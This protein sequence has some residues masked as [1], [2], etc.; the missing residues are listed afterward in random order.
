MTLQERNKAGMGA[1][2]AQGAAKLTQGGQQQQSRQ[3][4]NNT[5]RD[6]DMFKYVKTVH[7]HLYERNTESWV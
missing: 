7:V 5:H 1:F 2:V 6:S 3:V 4:R